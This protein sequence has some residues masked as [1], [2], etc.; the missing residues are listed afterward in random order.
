MT[1]QNRAPS[2]DLRCEPAAGLDIDSHRTRLITME[3]GPLLRAIGDALE[4]LYGD[5]LQGVVLYGSL[6]RGDED[7]DS[8]TDLLV[9]L[10]GPVEWSAELETVVRTL[11]PLQVK[12]GRSI[13]V[14][15]VDAEEYEAGEYALYRNARREG[16]LL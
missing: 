7:A 13:H 10:R 2:R 8:D 15:P 3:K 14:T 1:R 9:L 11:Y 6:A 5:R 16:V 4:R 12:Y